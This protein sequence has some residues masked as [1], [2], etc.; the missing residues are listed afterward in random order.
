[1]SFVFFCF[2]IKIRSMKQ[3]IVILFLVLPIV[4]WSQKYNSIRKYEEKANS[5]NFNK[6]TQLFQLFFKILLG[7]GLKFWMFFCK[8]SALGILKKLLSL[9][10]RINQKESTNEISE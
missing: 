9:N 4:G 10:L 5:M 1:M 6:K 2:K 7:N 3:F 8:V